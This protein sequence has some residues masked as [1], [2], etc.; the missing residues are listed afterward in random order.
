MTL[1]PDDVKLNAPIAPRQEHVWKRPTGDF[2]DPWAWLRNKND[3]KTL[4][5]LDEEN[6][7]ANN[8][9]AQSE[10][11]INTLFEEIKSRV[12][13]TDMSVPTQ[14]GPWWYVSKTIEGMA[15]AMHC[16]GLSKETATEH[17]I[18]DENAE[19]GEEEYFSLGVA[20]I[21]ADHSL[22]AWS[23]DTDGSEQYC[24][25]IRN[26]VDGKDLPDTLH[27]TSY[28]GAAFSANNEYLFYVVN[29]EALRPFRV[30]RHRIGEPQSSDVLVYEDLDERFFVGLGLTRSSNYIII[31]SACRTTSE[32][33]IIDAH[34]PLTPPKCARPREEGLEYSI[35]DWGSSFVVLTNLDAEDFCVHTAPHNAPGNWSI[36]IEHISG[37]RITDINPFQKFLVVYEWQDAQPHIRLVFPDSSQHAVAVLNEPHDV[38]LDSNPEWT[39]QTLRFQYQSLITPNTVAEYDVVEKSLKTL[40]QTV[41][42]NVDLS[43]FV[44]TRE[45]ATSHDGT[46][47][48]IDIVRHRDTLQDGSAPAVLYGYGSYEISIA[49]HFSVTR[50]SLLDRGWV[51]AITHPRGGGEMGRRWYLGG[52]LLTKRNTFL[53][54]IASA[55]YLVANKWA[56]TGGIALYGGSAGGLLVGACINMAPHV[57]GAAVAAVPFVDVV[58]TMSDPTLPL[59]VTEWEEWG[60]PRSEPWASYMLSYSPYDNVEDKKYPPLYVTAGL[61][62]PRV[63]YHEPAKWVAK[64]R[65][66]QNNT[67][68]IFFRCEMGAGH[69]GPS[70]RYEHWRDE[71]H[72]IAF[73]LQ[74]LPTHSI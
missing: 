14:H 58:S 19:A 55:E 16:R 38:E 10:P 74:Q 26:L 22:L 61:N 5:Y 28:G 7:Y 54:T 37:R 56:R 72:T 62:D 70:G 49:P 48:P 6:A 25:R 8:W 46:S 63:S 30:M 4:A 24:L 32:A 23:Y 15:Y 42:P 39:T 41:V 20:E 51:W 2:Q 73:M 43:Q 3:P 68:D 18:L 59:T 52:Q 67:S 71:A 53:D 34:S 57:F 44:A 33:H 64:L 47:V 50:F 66:M 27:D 12:Q 11:S 60:D 21:S 17:T 45:W 35:D 13:E 69:G 9:F 36:L 40:K 65:S 1:Y 29:D 31:E